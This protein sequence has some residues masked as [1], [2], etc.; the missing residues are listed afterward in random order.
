MYNS[1]L[2]LLLILCLFPVFLC[3]II[4]R[5]ILPWLHQWGPRHV[6]GALLIALPVG[7]ALFNIPLCLD[8]II[9]YYPPPN[10]PIICIHPGQLVLRLL[11]SYVLL[12]A[13]YTH[14]NF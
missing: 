8:K 11:Y 13:L 3:F 10:A 12:L 9:Y 6:L 1:G 14:C 7:V 5:P 4:R 2:L